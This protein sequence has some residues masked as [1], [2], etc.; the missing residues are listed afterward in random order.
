[1]KKFLT[2][3]LVIAVMFTFSFGSAFAINDAEKSLVITVDQALSYLEKDYNDAVD[4]LTDAM[5][6]DLSGTKDVDGNYITATNNV[7]VSKT[8]FDKALDKDT[9]Y[10]A[11]KKA[12]DDDYAA[13]ITAINNAAKADTFKGFLK[14]TTSSDPAYPALLAAANTYM[15][16]DYT[17]SSD[18]IAADFDAKA[19]VEAFKEVKA[20]TLAAISAITLDGVYSKEYKNATKSNYDLAKDAVDKAIDDIQK[21]TL[22]TEDEATAAAEIAAIKAIYVPATGK[23]KATGSLATALDAIEKIADAEANAT[24]LAYAQNKVLSTLLSQLSADKQAVVDFYNGKIRVEKDEDKPDTDKISEWTKAMADTESAFKD[25]ETAITYL[26]KY[27]DSY[28]DLGKFNTTTGKFE[29][30]TTWAAN[31]ALSL[32]PSDDAL[33]KFEALT[34]K[35][36]TSKGGTTD[37]QLTVKEMEKMAEEVAK[38][39]KYAKDDK[40]SVELDGSF[41]VKVDEALEN[42]IELIYTENKTAA[43]AYA[44]PL[45]STELQA[46]KNE[47]IKKDGVII[48]GKKY[49][50]AVNTWKKYANAADTTY[51]KELNDEIR[52][53][54]SETKAAIKAAAT[55]ADAEAAY[56]AGAEKLEAFVK[57][58]AHKNMFT[59]KNGALY[60]K[61]NKYVAQFSN[62]ATAQWNTIVALD[63]ADDYAVNNLTALI[64]YYVGS[65][66][67]TD[68]AFYKGIYDEAALDK[69]Y[70]EA[71][72]AV[73]GLKTEKEMTAMADAAKTAIEALPAAA[74]VADKESVL[75]AKK[76]YDEYKD[77]ADMIGA[78]SVFASK[79]AYV[80][81]LNKLTTAIED[82]QKAE[83]KAVAEL[84]K[85][86]PV[87][88]SDV[89]LADKEN[90]EAIRDM[91]DAYVNSYVDEDA[92]NEA[93]NG[94]YAAAIGG[95]ANLTKFEGT[96]G[97]E[98]YLDTAKVDNVIDLIKKLSVDPID[99]AAVKAAR[100]AY[101]ALDGDLQFRGATYNKL[102]ALEKLLSV[103]V[104]ALKLTA[105]SKATKGAITVKW[106]VKGNTSSA[107]GFQVWKST[108]M[109]KGYKKAFTT[110][111]TTYKNTKGLKKG[112][113]Y[114]YKVRA[115]KVVDGKMVYSDWSNK[116]YRT[117]K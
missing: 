100:E 113:K 29:M 50:E 61:Y 24:D 63:K 101:D 41:A 56:V 46:R 31:T 12:L 34:V 87:N 115:Y 60:D 64:N 32:N 51:D 2:V 82:I 97:Y 86:L 13:K 95:D 80:K 102:V 8:A 9:T 39:E 91:I 107:D 3:L 53:L 1:M 59:L 14:A 35:L 92:N 104:K 84:Y 23:A 117:A 42:A 16:E 98:E 76:L 103:D 52:A 62:Y 68:G 55:V 73:N 6:A 57:T 99:A 36:A 30:A 70:E 72:A 49:A 69:V 88:P 112:V 75:A 65:P 85:K 116:A 94:L 81:A 83:K 28:K 10:K 79:A 15:M 25:A 47:L 67:Y 66:A 18:V 21:I 43:Q 71:M 27:A 58:A 17:Y 78:T 54:V 105:S 45:N 22:A 37:G 5:K 40:D 48:N 4:D 11:A 90:I 114:Y 38:A 108:K 33:A 77:Y 19:A 89:T 44:T 111:K 96:N 7:V 93:I 106:T 20:D 74:T 26:V 109:N 110:T